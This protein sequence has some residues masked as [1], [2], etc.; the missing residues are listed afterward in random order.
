MRRLL[1]EHRPEQSRDNPSQEGRDRRKDHCLIA[2]FGNLVSDIPLKIAQG[3]SV[4]TIN[5]LGQSAAPAM[6]A[7]AECEDRLR[8]HGQVEELFPPTG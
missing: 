2:G 5:S 1:S 6:L 7:V 8:R 4:G 3:C